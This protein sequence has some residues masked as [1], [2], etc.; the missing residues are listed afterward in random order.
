MM[1]M[2][3]QTVAFGGGIPQY[4]AENG[5]G[6]VDL[7]KVEGETAAEKSLA[8]GSLNGAVP[9]AFTPDMDTKE[10]PAREAGQGVFAMDPPYVDIAGIP[11]YEGI[12]RAF[13]GGLLDSCVMHLHPD[14]V[15]PRAQLLMV[16]F[17]ALRLAGCRPYEGHFTDL[18]RFEWDSSYVQACLNEDLIDPA[19]VTEDLFRPDDP[20]TGE[21]FA[22]FCERGI[23]QKEQRAGLSLEEAFSRAKAHGILPENVDRK[24]PLTRADV[25]TGLA[26]VMDLLN[27][28]DQALPKDA[29]IHPV[30]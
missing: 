27:N 12:V 28:A 5:A 25:Y 9:A 22:S 13:P 26:R 16:L 20:L 18:G 23:V 30:G 6:F 1:S 4:S 14:A 10:V 21:E 29:E 3:S 8:A 7:S 2:S 15:L 24:A 11:Q 19:T 17:K